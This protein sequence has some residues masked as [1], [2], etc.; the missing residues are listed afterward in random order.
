MNDRFDT[1]TNIAEE[2]I[3]RVGITGTGAADAT[4]RA[5]RG[6]TV[7]R[8]GV[9]VHRVTFAKN[10]GTF[11]GLA[12][13]VF[14]ADT[15]SAVKGYTLTASPPVSS[16]GTQYIDISIWNSAFAAADLAAAQYLDVSFLF[17]AQSVIT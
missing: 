3:T 14:R 12:G 2:R 17:A 6:F 4:V 16:G 10:P 5:G 9:G 15:A 1:K 8:Q 7:T 11:V 13:A